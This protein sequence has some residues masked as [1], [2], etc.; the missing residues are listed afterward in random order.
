MAHDLKEV[1]ELLNLETLDRYLFRGYSPKGRTHMVFGGQVVAQAIRA[2]TATV[3]PDR[4]LHSLHSYFLRPGN[5]QNPIL[6]YVDPIRNGHSFTTRRV[7]AKQDGCAI[8]SASLSFHRQEQGV[9]HQVDM[10][11]VP[12]PEELENDEAYFE[13]FA[14]L[15]PEKMPIVQNRYTSIECRPVQRMDHLNPKPMGTRRQIWMRSNGP[16]PDDPGIHTAMLAFLSDLYLMGT[17]LGPHGLSFL[18]H[19]LQGASLDHGLWIHA[20]CRCDQWLLYDMESPRAIGARG[21]NHGNI[22]TREGIL[23]AS[24]I[25]EGLMRIKDR[26]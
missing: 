11:D 19:N 25:Q 12:P 5:P 18:T 26:T 7:V 4:L 17:A 23:A 1:L 8:F 10:P 14:R 16:L 22:Y 3:E 20:P 6:F 2:A 21:L 15:F 24:T 9:E 13:R